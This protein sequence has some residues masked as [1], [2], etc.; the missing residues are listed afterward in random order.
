ML[1]NVNRDTAIRFLLVFLAL[2]IIA[3]YAASLAVARDV[4]QWQNSDQ[5]IAEWY[6]TLMQPD[7]PSIPCCGEADA[8]WADEYHVNA[9]GELIVTVTDDRP[10]EPLKRPHISAGTMFVV[11][12]NKL[13][14][15]RGN[16]TGHS[17]LFVRNSTGPNDQPV[18]CFVQGGGA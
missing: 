12:A 15:D 9:R 17:V 16:P 6:R 3:I 5:R 10:D 8:Y 4:G 7:N 2:L 13:K 1:N 14:W 18:Y 11:P